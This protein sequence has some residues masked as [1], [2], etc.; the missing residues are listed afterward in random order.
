MKQILGLVAA[1]V[2]ALVAVLLVNTWRLV[3]RRVPVTS[4]PD[5]PPP[6]PPAKAAARLAEGLRFRTLSGDTSSGEA[7]TALHRHLEASFPRV[8]A[9]F[10]REAVSGFSLLYTWK[11]SDPDLP[12]VVCMGHQ[13]VVP[14]EPGTADEWTHPP[15][16]GV[17]ADGAVWGRGALDIK[18]VVYGLLEAAESLLAAGYTPRRTIYFVFGDNEEVGGDGA[19][20]IARRLEAEGVRPALV[21]DEGM[22]VTQGIVPGIDRPVALVGVAEKGD[23]SVTLDL[24]T[25]GGHS[26]MPGSH[27]AAG[28]V[29]RAVTRLEQHPLPAHLRGVGAS[30]FGALAPEMAFPMR[31]AF[32][33]LWLTRPLIERRL[34]AVPSTNALIRTTT[35]VT[36]LESGIR[37]NVVP[38]RA[39]AL[40]N[41]RTLPGDTVE[42]IVDHVR[43]TVNDDR[44][45]VEPAGT[46]RPASPVSPVD[47]PGFIL[48]QELI[49][50]DFPGSV[51][52]PGMVLGGTDSRHF[53]AL[54]PAV[55]RFVP[56]RVG[57]GDLERFHG[58]NERI[59]VEDYAAAIRFYTDFLAVAGGTDWPAS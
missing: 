1:A 20:S 56:I 19:A 16:G 21:L 48:L 6:V 34:A 46:P 55:Y 22:A 10:A 13:D 14:V 30:M 3:S 51:V 36:L 43:R 45:R 18:E 41:F 42:G 4:G 28:L 12:P 47:G 23:V 57:P 53:A 37:A 54:T 9:A 39:R 17:I 25:E 38:R 26:A 7:F 44:I 40:V 5:L 8:H 35:A 15:F 29:A 50:R 11:G 31:A 52:A 33:N 32:A 58:V 2:V 24:E 49:R 27:T 59:R